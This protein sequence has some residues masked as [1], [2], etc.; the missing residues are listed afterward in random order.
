MF[1]HTKA[2]STLATIVA[3]FGDNLSP[4]LA[5]VAEFC[6][7]TVAEFALSTL[8]TIVAEFG[9]NLSPVLATVAQFGAYSRQCGQG[10]TTDN[11]RER[12]DEV[13]M[14]TEK[15]S[16]GN[17][18]TSQCQWVVAQRRRQRIVDAIS[19]VACN[20]KTKGWLMIR[21]K[22]LCIIQYK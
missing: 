11:S 19:C 14:R 5:T 22:R 16:V 17:R 21:M 2:L 6:D 8:A 18:S 3:E 12:A 20:T 10:L 1:A 9:D 13:Y 7:R 4:F 15:S